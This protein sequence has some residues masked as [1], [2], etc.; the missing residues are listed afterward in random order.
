MPLLRGLEST[1]ARGAKVSPKT[2]DHVFSSSDYVVDFSASAF[3]KA[4]PC[5]EQT[6]TRVESFKG[7]V[8]DVVEGRVAQDQFV[9]RLEDLGA[10]EVEA[11]DYVQLLEQRLV[12]QHKGV[13]A[14][15][16]SS[17]ENQVDNAGERERTPE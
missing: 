1:W 3:I 12:Q 13:S 15:Q 10:S 6:R 14:G 17:A 7:L 8:D 4:P 16:S 2:E 9:Q 5:R 11:K